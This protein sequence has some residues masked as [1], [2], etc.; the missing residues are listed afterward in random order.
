MSAAKCLAYLIFFPG[1]LCY[2]LWA[3][4]HLFISVLVLCSHLNNCAKR[5]GS[6]GAACTQVYANQKG[7]RSTCVAVI[8]MCVWFVSWNKTSVWLCYGYSSDVQSILPFSCISAGL[9]LQPCT[10]LASHPTPCTIWD[11]QIHT[12]SHWS[13]AKIAHVFEPSEL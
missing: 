11:T 7:E 6:L 12:Q 10:H 3:T 2:Y 5:P 4:C 13:L 9:E 1:S 8:T